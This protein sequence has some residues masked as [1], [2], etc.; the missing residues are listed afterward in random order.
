VTDREQ[1]LRIALQNVN[2]RLQR[3]EDALGSRTLSPVQQAEARSDVARC[4]A[5]QDE[6]YAELDALNAPED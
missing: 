2:R 4:E 1:E 3:A 6:I 5:E